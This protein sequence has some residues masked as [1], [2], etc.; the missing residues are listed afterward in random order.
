[1]P[2]P[3]PP[4]RP[5]DPPLAILIDYDG[6]I[7]LTDVTDTVLAEHAPGTWEEADAAYGEGRVGSRWTMGRHLSLLPPDPDPLL[8]TA[9]RQPHDPVF[10]PFVR[11]ALAAGAVVEVVSDGLGFFIGP[12]LRRLGLPEL[13]VVAAEA[14]FD[15]SGP[16]LE[17]PNGDPD[18]HVCGTCKRARVRAH[19]AA[20]RQVV[21]VGDGQSDRYAALYA[22]RVFAKRRLIGIC[23]ELGVAHT[24][25]ERFAEL[26]RWLAT[27]LERWAADPGHLGP[28][29]PRPPVCGAEIWG[30]GRLGTPDEEH[31]AGPLR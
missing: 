28:P 31:P 22:D 23:E 27:T 29:V 18:C 12:A 14:I 11:R 13:P 1:M 26:D 20:G 10:V 25:F 30:P 5:D 21:F 17:F 7:A 19:Q 6:T 3:V 8:A 4:L 2:L 24:R 15:P 9:A 16:R